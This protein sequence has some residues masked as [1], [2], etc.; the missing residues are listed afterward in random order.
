MLAL[1]KINIE[2]DSTVQTLA[3]QQIDYI[4]GN[5]PRSGSYIIGFGSSWPQSP[6]H[7]GANPTQAS[8]AVNTCTGM[9]VG[10]PASNND[11]FSDSWSVYAQAEGGL[12][13]NAGLIGALAAMVIQYG[14]GGGG[15]SS[16]SAATSA[17]NSSS[18]ATSAPAS[19]SSVATSAPS[20][21]SSVAT[22]APSSATSSTGSTSGNIKV[23]TFQSG[24]AT[25]NQLNGRFQLVNTGSTAIAL[26]T[27]KIHYYLKNQ[28]VTT[29]NWNCD[30]AT[31]GTANVSG[32][33]GAVNP[34]QTGA[35]Q[36]NEITFSASAGSLAPGAS[37]EI[38]SRINKT[39]WSNIDNSL[40]YSY[41]PAA[42]YCDWT[43]VT[44][45]VNG[46]LVWGTEPGGGTSSS[47]A[48]S[49]PSS[50]SSTATS[51]PSSSSVA[52][53][54]PSSSSS[55]ATSAPSSS[56][57]VASSS[58]SS[59]VSSSASSVAGGLKILMFNN[60]K[61]DGQNTINP[62]IMISNTGSSAVALSAVKVRYYFTKDV[63]STIT[64]ELDSSA[65]QDGGYSDI[66]SY[67][68]GTINALSPTKTGADT[69]LEITF[70]S[71]AGNLNANGFVQIGIRIHT[72]DWLSFTESNDYS[73][74]SVDS[75][76]TSWTKMTAYQ[77]GSLVWG[78]EPN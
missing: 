1:K 30:F 66:K 54:A 56:S 75:A 5:N 12:D 68:T 43:K 61:G 74:D 18:T 34:V 58:S 7:R 70:A 16:S 38:Q 44:V 24:N 47:T 52:T 50:S 41:N 39:D 11:S 4:M 73:Y 32:A 15:S 37:S 77:T 14:G 51:A 33:F 35:D 69:Y 10:G 23:Q 76:F 28:G 8:V 65:K 49:A 9:L 13:Y 71:G 57:S 22:S 36:Y 26:S 42:S 25:N 6:H 48:T 45:Y 46:T 72:T 67:T 63:S 2:A 62:N 29:Y 20:S 64:N 40:N 19:S 17:P 53:S 31:A 3:K 55:V 59:A 78:T 21:S 60:T 27:V